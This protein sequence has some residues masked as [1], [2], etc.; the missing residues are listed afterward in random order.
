MPAKRPSGV[1]QYRRGA[2]F[3]RHVKQVL[4]S[5]A[6]RALIIG[7]DRLNYSESRIGFNT[8]LLAL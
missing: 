7:V 4:E 2:A 3:E 1:K 6:G 8:G 5:L